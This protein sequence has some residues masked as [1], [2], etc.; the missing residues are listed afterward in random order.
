MP[1]ITAVPITD[2]VGFF[3]VFS[4]GIAVSKADGLAIPEA[5]FTAVRFLLAWQLHYSITVGTSW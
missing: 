4:Y 3:F 1:D 2:I 5:D